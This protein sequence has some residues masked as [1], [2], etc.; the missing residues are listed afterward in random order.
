VVLVNYAAHGTI[1]TPEIMQ[2]SGGWP[3]VMQRTVEALL[4]EDVTCLYTNGAEGDVAP[5]DYHGGSRWEMAE[6]YGRRAGIAASKLA[7]AARTR[8]VTDFRVVAHTMELPG[9]QPAPDFL[10][11]AG[12]EYKVDEAQLTMLLGVLFPRQAPLYGLRINDFAMITYP[13]EPITAIGMD[14]KRALRQG[15]IA[16]PAVAALT[17]DLI[18]YILTEEEYHQSGYEVTASFYGPGLGAVVTEN[19]KALAAKLVE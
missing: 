12:D 2:V 18:G 13:G 9:Q 6:N 3:G 8:P 14:A 7:E 4:G 17:N 11:I 16:Y 19:A 10:K 1:M 5:A 15:N